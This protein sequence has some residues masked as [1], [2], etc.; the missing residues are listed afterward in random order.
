MRR[1]YKAI[2]LKKELWANSSC[3][4]DHD[5]ALCYS[6]LVFSSDYIDLTQFKHRNKGKNLKVLKAIPKKYYF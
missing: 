6:A 5:N 4:F 1:L 3:F 2:R